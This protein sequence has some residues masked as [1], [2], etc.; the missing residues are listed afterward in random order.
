M[1]V[2]NNYSYNESG[3]M[4]FMDFVDVVLCQQPSLEDGIQE[5]VT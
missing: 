2:H 5:R 4:A 3:P 1:T